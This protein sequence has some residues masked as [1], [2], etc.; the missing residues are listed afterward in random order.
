MGCFVMLLIDTN[1]GGERVIERQRERE[2]EGE[3]EER[4]ERERERERERDIMCV[5]VRGSSCRRLIQKLSSS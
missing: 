3:R 2:R 5:R 1:R 4:G